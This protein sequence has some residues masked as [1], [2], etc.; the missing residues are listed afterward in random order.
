MDVDSVSKSTGAIAAIL[1]V[2][3]AVVNLFWAK[4]HEHT[5]RRQIM[6]F[7]TGRVN[8]WHNFLKAELAATTPGSDEQRRFK[9]EVLQGIQLVRSDTNCEL[10]RLSWRRTVK[11]TIGRVGP[12]R[13]PRDFHLGEISLAGRDKFFFWGYV[14]VAWLLL[15]QVVICTALLVFRIFI[16]PSIGSTYLIVALILISWLIYCSV[17]MLWQA[18]IMNFLPPSPARKLDK[19]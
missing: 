6:N 5:Q 8:I 3:V 15:L 1:G 11:Q 13:T 10:E 17:W 9:A 14:I 19:I 4:F 18:E 12:I 7:A 2:F 16:L